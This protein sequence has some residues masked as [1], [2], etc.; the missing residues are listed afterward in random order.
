VF[1]NEIRRLYN[2]YGN[3]NVHIWNEHSEIEG[4]FQ[5]YCHR[6]GGLRNIMNELG[7]QHLQYNQ[8]TKEEI[9]RCCHI[10]L[11]KEGKLRSEILDKYGVSGCVVKRLFGSYQNMYKEIGYESGFHRNVEFNDVEQDILK[12]T[13]EHNS[14]SSLTYRKYGKY[15]TTITDRF[16]GWCAVLRRIGI[17]PIEPKVGKEEIDKQI[18]DVI[19]EYGYLSNNLIENNCSFSLQALMWYYGSVDK[20]AKHYNT[21][22]YSSVRMSS[23]AKTVYQKLVDKYGEDNVETEKTWPWLRN[24]TGKHL[25]CDF[26]IPQINTAI[27]YDGEQHFKFVP[28]IHKTQEAFDALVARDMLKNKLLRENGVAL[29]RIPYSTK[30]ENSLF[31]DL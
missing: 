14:I 4:N 9:I 12:V 22:Y 13:R 3:V 31:D 10:A 19:N 30:I 25:Y 26:Y 21:E 23:G 15:S 5:C 27:E 28:T 16:G 8:K 29:I 1:V 17:E 11:E 20:L 2:I 24:I 18:Y 6:F 7:L